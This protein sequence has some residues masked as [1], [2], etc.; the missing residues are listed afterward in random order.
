MPAVPDEKFTE[1]MGDTQIYYIKGAD[2][3]SDIN[4]SLLQWQLYTSADNKM[5]TKMSN[6]AEVFL[7]DAGIN[8]DPIISAVIN[9]NAG[10]V[11]GYQCDEL[12]ITTKTGVQKYYYSSKV[13]VDSK[14]FEGHKFMNWDIIMQKTHALP[15]KMIAETGQFTLESVATEIKP[16]K[17]EKSF[18]T[19][20]AGSKT[21]KSP[22]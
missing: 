22:Y 16:M 15:L 18:F 9:K 8:S 12:T 21:V 14:L 4:G 5:Y 20:P 2:Y 10:V 1:L 7:N 6:A 17:L 13:P 11:L 3:K 19:L